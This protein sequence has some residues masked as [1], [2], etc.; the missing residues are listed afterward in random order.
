MC[1]PVGTGAR[2]ATASYPEC[3]VRLWNIA[4]GELRTTL[5]KTALGVRA[6]AFSPVRTLLAI[7]GEDGTAVLWGVNEARE[8]GTVRA[9]ERGLQSIA[10][11][12]DGRVLATGGTDGYA[13][14]GRGFSALSVRGK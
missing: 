1:V 6:L 10:F 9:N 2:F 3:E 13:C 8:L 7:A 11:S 5:P 14:L 12:N 4:D